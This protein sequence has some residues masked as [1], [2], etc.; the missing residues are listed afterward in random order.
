MASV[1]LLA[2]AP[3]CRAT[4]CC[5][6]QTHPMRLCPPTLP[7]QHPSSLHPNR[8]LAACWGCSPVAGGAHC[9]AAQKEALQRRAPPGMQ[10]HINTCYMNAVLQV[11]ANACLI[12][13]ATNC[14]QHRLHKHGPAGGLGRAARMVRASITGLAEAFPR[15]CRKHGSQKMD[16]CRAE[17]ARAAQ[18]QGCIPCSG[19]LPVAPC[20]SASVGTVATTPSA[21]APS[22]GT[23]ATALRRCTI[24]AAVGVLAFCA[25]ERVSTPAHWHAAWIARPKSGRGKR[26]RRA[27]RE[28]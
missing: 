10:N 19:W 25:A 5:T 8:L 13:H 20:L 27:T 21:G 11:G 23:V 7:C 22:L 6:P 18:T 24:G 26:S 17:K 28:V 1:T 15:R 9:A 14:S 2:P 3:S 12:K 16:T 4:C